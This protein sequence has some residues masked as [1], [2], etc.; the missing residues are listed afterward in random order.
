MS[1]MGAGTPRWI[2]PKIARGVRGIRSMFRR[3]ARR[4]QRFYMRKG[5]RRARRFLKV[6][7]LEGAE[8]QRVVAGAQVGAALADVKS[9]RLS[10]NPAHNRRGG[11]VSGARLDAAASCALKPVPQV[12]SEHV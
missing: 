9:H 11:R 1:L 8:E 6:L 10:S 5:Q 4:Q 12:R 3:D 7:G 2:M